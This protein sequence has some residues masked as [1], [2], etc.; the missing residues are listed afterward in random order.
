MKCLTKLTGRAK[1]KKKL[2][3][4][5]CHFELRETSHLLDELREF[6]QELKESKPNLKKYKLYDVG[7]VPKLNFILVK[8]YFYREVS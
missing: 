1:V 4:V 3:T 7:F 2:L 6:V 8:L 5:N